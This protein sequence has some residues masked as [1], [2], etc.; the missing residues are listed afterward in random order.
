MEIFR[1]NRKIIFRWLLAAGVLL[2]GGGCGKKNPSSNNSVPLEAT[3]SSIQVNI[4]DERCAFSG[5][6]AAPDAAEGLNLEPGRSFTNLVNVLSRQN[7]NL[8]RVLPFAPDQSYLVHKLEGVNIG[9]TARM[10]RSGA[11][12][13]TEEIN[14]VR[15]WIEEG[16][17]PN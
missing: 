3:L 1:K 2:F 10:P 9:G 16:A 17:Q 6:H 8:M 12:L 11:P 4:F 14:V 5:C 7:A 13:S 15:K